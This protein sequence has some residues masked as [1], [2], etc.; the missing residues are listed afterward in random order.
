MVLTDLNEMGSWP[1][2]D[3]RSGDDKRVSDETRNIFSSVSRIRVLGFG[4][5]WEGGQWMRTDSKSEERD[6]GEVIH[7]S[8]RF[9][10]H[11]P[12]PSFQLQILR[13]KVG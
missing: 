12:F 2:C 10:P 1:V 6:D 4:V 7:T 13:W 8:N 3:Q 5:G 9:R 11:I